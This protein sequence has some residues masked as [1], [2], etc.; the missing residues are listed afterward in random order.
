MM[1]EAH[2]LILA[3]DLT[4]AADSAA[5]CAAQGLETMVLLDPD[6]APSASSFAPDVLAVDAATRGLLRDEAR[7]RAGKIA[8]AHAERSSG[9]LFKKLDSLLR[10]H[11]GE[12]LAGIHHALGNALIVLAP[13]FPAIGRTTCGGRQWWNGEP[14]RGA[15]ALAIVERAG[16]RAANLNTASLPGGVEGLAAAME[17]LARSNDVV[18]CDAVTEEELER[19]ARAAQK[20]ARE[21]ANHTRVVWAGS[22]GLGRY[23][24]KAV[25]PVRKS[26]TRPPVAFRGSILTAV[27]SRTEMAHRQASKLAEADGVICLSADPHTL[28]QGKDSNDWHQQR[29]LLRRALDAGRDVIVTIGTAGDQKE[30]PGLCRALAAFIAPHLQKVGAMVLTGGETA[31]AVLKSAGLLAL[32]LR[33]EVERGVPLSIA[34]GDS[35]MP[36]I[37]K[38]GSF[39]EP[40]TLVH[41]LGVLRGLKLE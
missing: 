33:E 24:P 23:I 37:T 40:G 5:A 14:V 38:S 2:A 26:R 19:V 8:A 32:R 4:G 27:G 41:C 15:D 1:T 30:D 22:A 35:S 29:E 12:E 20:L 9:L 18:V 10:G 3:D 21:I 28:R 36:V 34:S 25:G 17:E 7:A 39:G 16:L 11:V 31:R 13:A 6:R